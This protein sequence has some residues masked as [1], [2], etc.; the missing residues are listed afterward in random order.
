MEEARILIERIRALVNN[1]S[2]RPGR[3]GVCSGG[4]RIPQGRKHRPKEASWIKTYIS[5]GFIR[6]RD[7]P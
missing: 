7:S 6:K 3:Y 4:V 5:H 2:P 1:T